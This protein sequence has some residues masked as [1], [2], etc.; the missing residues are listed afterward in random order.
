[1]G[2]AE[3]RII[4]TFQENQYESF[5]KEVKEVVGKDLEIDVAWDTIALDGMS[6]LYEKAWPQVYFEPTI[7]ALKSICADDIGKEA[8]AGELNKIVIKN[9]GGIS[10]AHKWVNFENNTLTLDHKPTTN[11]GQISDRVKSLQEL[12]ENNL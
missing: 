8:I 12:L 7:T 5:L 9:E 2:L 6:H 4:K 10:S 11:L 3:R 1:M